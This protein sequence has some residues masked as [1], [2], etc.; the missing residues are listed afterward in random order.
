MALFKF[1]KSILNNE[2]IEVFNYGKHKRD[3]IYIDNIVEGVIRILDVSAQ[4]NI[5]WNSDFPDPGTSNAPWRIYNIGNNNPIELMTYVREIERAK[6]AL[7][8]VA[9]RDL[10]DMCASSWRWQENIRKNFK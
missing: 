10:S 9:K 6:S 7:G 2:S 5:L 1:V 3:F 8:W 4:K